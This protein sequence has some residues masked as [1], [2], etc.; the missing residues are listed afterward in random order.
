[1]T[2][3]RAFQLIK[4]VFDSLGEDVLPDEPVTVN[5]DTLLLGNNSPLDSIGFITFITALEERL[6]QETNNDD[7]YL[8]LDEIGDF[9][10]NNPVLS[11]D[12]LARHLV[13][14]TSDGKGNNK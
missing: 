2:K 3:D 6:I 14:L 5:T 13:K 8:V 10:V 9:N 4:E 1:M 7:I 12:A 11:I